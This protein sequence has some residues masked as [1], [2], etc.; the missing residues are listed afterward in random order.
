MTALEQ[1]K[2]YVK[3]ELAAGKQVHWDA[4]FAA[5]RPSLAHIREWY[6]DLPR[7]LKKADAIE[8]LAR[9]ACESVG[10]REAQP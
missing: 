4:A 8:W 6:K 2:A 3:A 1:I 10:I 7:D 9:R 5:S